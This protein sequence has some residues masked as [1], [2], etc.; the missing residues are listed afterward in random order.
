MKSGVM[1]PIY[2]HHLHYIIGCLVFH[3]QVHSTKQLVSHIHQVNLVSQ[4]VG[5]WLMFKKDIEKYPSFFWIF[6]KNLLCL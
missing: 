4:V 6:E 1:L 3:Q 2:Q 5:Q